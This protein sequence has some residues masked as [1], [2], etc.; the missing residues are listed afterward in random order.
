MK[1]LTRKEIDEMRSRGY[2]EETFHQFPFSE[3]RT[4]LAEELCAEIRR[5][6]CGV[7][8]GYG[9]GLH[10]AQAID[11]YSSDSERGKAKASDEKESWERIA[12]ADLNACYSSLS[13]F[14]AEGFRFHLPAY[15]I[16]D[17]R[18]EFHFGMSYCLTESC[19]TDRFLLLNPRQR[20]AVRDYLIFIAED[21]DYQFER[22]HILRALDDGWSEDFCGKRRN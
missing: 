21:P 11:D 6:F 16:A 10:E 9:V 22:S 7:T 14:D 4:A 19:L 3:A 8:L 13:F 5:A 17:L 18:G 2:E 12:P 15:L 20:W 1:R